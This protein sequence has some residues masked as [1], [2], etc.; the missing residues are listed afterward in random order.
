MRAED[1]LKLLRKRRT[2]VYAAERTY[3]DALIYLL[4]RLDAEEQDIKA[5]IE[6]YNSLESEKEYG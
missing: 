6:A 4:E 1:Y 3:V 5:Q 2:Q